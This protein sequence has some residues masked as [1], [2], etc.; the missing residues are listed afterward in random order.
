ME[1]P[2]EKIGIMGGGN[3]GLFIGIGIGIGLRNAVIT[4]KKIIS[5]ELTE[6][7]LIT[8]K[9]V[10]KTFII[11]NTHAHIDKLKVK[12]LHKKRSKYF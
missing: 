8:P 4:D 5:A 3:F 12:P 11:K 6:V 1:E 2:L 7:S 10:P 9:P